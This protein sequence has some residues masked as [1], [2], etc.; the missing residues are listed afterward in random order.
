LRCANG[1]DVRVDPLTPTAVEPLLRG[2]FGHPY[3]FELIV[4]STQELVAADDPEGAVVCAE[5]Q[6]DGRGRLGRR[7]SAPPG[8]AL[9]FSMLLRP[10]SDRRLPEL[11]LV[12]G[13]AL[14]EVVEAE[15]SLPAA[16]K[17]PNDVLVDG[18]K[19]CGILAELRSG[20]V[21]LGVG[22]NVNQQLHELPT[23]TGTSAT[24]LRAVDGRIRR[25]AALLAQILL[26]LERRYDE[27]LALGLAPLTDEFS[28]RDFLRGRRVTAGGVGGVAVGI[29]VHGRLELDVAGD[30]HAVEGGEILYER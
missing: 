25:R 3:R 26:Q 4:E 13:I 20:A 17:W 14:A 9:T 30:R 15:L 1:E 5:E 29:D 10:P 27:W 21:V 23:E 2:R 19:I 8:L 12:A 16:I 18:A 22:L 24:S 6:R 28:R 11:S 7:W